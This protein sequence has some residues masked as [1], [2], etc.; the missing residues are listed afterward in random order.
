MN[1]LKF[2]LSDNNFKELKAFIDK[3]NKLFITFTTDSKLLVY[4]KFIDAQLTIE[5]ISTNYL[6]SNKTFILSKK[7]IEL[8]EIQH[9]NLD[10]CHLDIDNA[11]DDETLKLFKL[12][13]ISN[14]IVNAQHVLSIDKHFVT[15]QLS[16]VN[17]KTT[18]KNA[19][20]LLNE[21]CCLDIIHQQLIFIYN[22][23][24]ASLDLEHSI[25]CSDNSIKHL[26]L[27]K[28][29]LQTIVKLNKF[30]ENTIF[31]IKVYKIDDKFILYTR[32]YTIAI[33]HEFINNIS[34]SIVNHCNNRLSNFMHDY[35]IVID[36]SKEFKKHIQSIKS[37]IDDKMLFIHIKD[38]KLYL[39]NT[40]EFDG[41]SVSI[42]IN[43]C[44][45]D[46]AVVICN[47]DSLLDI[48]KKLVNDR[49]ELF[50]NND[51]LVITE[52]HTQYYLLLRK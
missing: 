10:I 19:N 16:L 12:N 23:K 31:P 11:L 29:I 21:N 6:L 35:K 37:F 49:T 47:Y 48:F 3:N 5:H 39:C 28:H 9:N 7:D 17:L 40:R 24:I 22:D 26:S 44:S 1:K 18:S 43:D 25:E 4:N 8:L 46:N 30:N 51:A 36:N 45:N 14:K 42:Y 20:F 50:I 34:S 13:D 2:K 41:S 32:F 52:N 33:Y 38:D 27:N 15:K